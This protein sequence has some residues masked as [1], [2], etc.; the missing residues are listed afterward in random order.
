MEGLAG[1]RR[2]SQP[3][4]RRYA[5]LT[6]PAYGPDENA[7]WAFSPSAGAGLPFFRAGRYIII[8]EQ[9]HGR[10]TLEKRAEMHHRPEER[11][12]RGR[13][14]GLG[15]GGKRLRER[16]DRRHQPFH[17]APHIQRD[18]RRRSATRS[19]RRSRRWA[20]PSTRSRLT[21]IRSIT[22][23]SRATP[24]KGACGSLSMP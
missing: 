21:T 11:G 13:R 19:P 17:R 14:P 22:S 3:P 8:G 24:S 7:R 15:G 16:E 23:S 5:A 4:G 9:N 1:H 10:D 2:D 12:G 20:A 6:G 18:G